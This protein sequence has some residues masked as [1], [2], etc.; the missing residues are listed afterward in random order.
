MEPLQ[1]IY[2]LLKDNVIDYD[3]ASC[4]ATTL[5]VLKEPGR[6]P[7]TKSYVYCIRGGP[8]GKSVVLYDYNANEHQEFIHDWFTGFQGYLHVD[9]DNFFNLLGDDNATIVNCNAHARR[10]FEPIAKSNKGKGIAKEAMRYFKELY[11]I[12][13]DAK[14]DKLNS[15]QRY[16][17][18]Q[19]K[20]KPLFEEFN[21]W[22]DKIAPTV[23][24]KSTLG[25]AVNYCIKYRA[26]IMRYLEDGRLEI[27][28]N[29]TEQEIK[30]L[31]IAR[32]NFLFCDSV[33]G[34]KALCL[35]FGLIR[36]AKL[37]G[38]DPY[39]YYVMLLKNVP[40]CKS[41]EDYEKL[42]PWNIKPYLNLKPLEV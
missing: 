36:T 14:N 4:D 35:H 42:L 1:P 23:L 41:I 39:H 27:D 18:R 37:H 12:E 2:N 28:N 21:A 25:G 6:N 40:H 30:P 17:L 9:G 13:R 3:V 38:L 8:P 16:Q 15:E 29:L 31:V 26:G 24:P 19:D 32:K 11:K 7:E 20:A 5:Q 33:A 10:K 34:A 22:I